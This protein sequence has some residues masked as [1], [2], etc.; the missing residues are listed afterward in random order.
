[1]QYQIGDFAKMAQISHKQLKYYEQC[2]LLTPARID[3]D[4]GYR[5]YEAEQLRSVAHVRAFMSMGFATAEI[6]ELLTAADYTAA[7]DEKQA[8]LEEAI[9]EYRRKLALLSFYRDAIR[10]HDFNQPYRAA[11][12]TT[13]QGSFAML[14]GRFRD[15]DALADR[16]PLLLEDVRNT[17]A[18]V[19]PALIT[20]AR[21]RDGDFEI[22]NFDAE[23]LLKVDRRGEA[24][25]LFGYAELTPVPAV[26]VIHRGGYALINEA[27]AFAY[28]WIDCNG[29]RVGGPP[30]ES[31]LC[32]PASGKPEKD[33]V[34]ELYIP[35]ELR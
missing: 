20:L 25:E 12:K 5:Y 27:Y 17:G 23:L 14:R 18:A 34:T 24:S 29:Y 33:F 6:K 9:D 16:W 13:P 19:S 1:M 4:S 28:M 26:S 15:A 11:V 2:G 35:I 8:E 7:F 32:G 31:Y 30:I 22:E 21:F 10:S 3:P